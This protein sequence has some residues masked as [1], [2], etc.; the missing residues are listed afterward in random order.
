M[1]V[2]AD[3]QWLFWDVDPDAID[4]ARDRRYVLGRVLERG[5]MVDVRWVFA[6]YGVEGVREF[7]RTGAH[8]EVSG[9]TRALWRTF[10]KEGED[11]WTEAP[12]WRNDSVAP[13][14]G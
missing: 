6:V 2:P 10:L 4:L 8:P 13:W 9:P 11:Q 7:F 12:S 5:R 1:P 3:S 14:V